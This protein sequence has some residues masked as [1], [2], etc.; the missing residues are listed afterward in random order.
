MQSTL[1]P[2]A[3]LSNFRK[4]IDQ[5]FDKFWSMEE[6]ELPL[7]LMEWTP[8]I[9][10]LETKD[11]LLVK[12]EVPGID[13]AEIHVSYQDKI[14]TIRG[15]KKTEKKEKDDRYFRMERASGSFIRHFRVPVPVEGNRISAIFKNGLL[16]V[17]LPKAPE[18][19]TAEIPIK[20]EK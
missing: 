6:T 1:L 18:A 12:A 17:T 2:V 7:M 19:K 4:E 14:L 20:E 5:L 3:P 16:T 15:E 8:K 11:A 13:P 9:D 10:I